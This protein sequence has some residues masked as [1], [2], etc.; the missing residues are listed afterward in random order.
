MLQSCGP[1]TTRQEWHRVGMDFHIALARLSGNEF[2]YRGVREAMTLLSRARWLEVR[3]EQARNHAWSE[4]HL[5]LS[6]V[7][8]GDAEEAAVLLSRHV[9]GG[10]ERLI[11][12]LRDDRRG[13]KARGFAIIAA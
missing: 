5:I 2:L 6:A 4:H 8:A 1:E 9:T 10:R 7:Q 11:V 3:D 12:S 13:L